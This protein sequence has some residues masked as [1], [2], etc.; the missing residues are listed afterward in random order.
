MKCANDRIL[1]GV[2]YP[3]GADETFTYDVNGNRLTRNATTYTYNSADQ[4]T[5][6]GNSSYS[7]DA[8]GNQT[9]RGSDS[10]TW[11]HENRLKSATIGG[12]TTYTYNGD[13]LPDDEDGGRRRHYIWDVA[14]ALPVIVQEMQGG[15]VTNSHI[16]AGAKALERA[17]A[18]C[19]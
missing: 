11:D 13:G 15:S 14:A 6:D 3:T 5:N 17:F 2:D 1:F 16:Y 12:T 9:A 8:N 10:F 4:L 19:D 7:Y 18:R